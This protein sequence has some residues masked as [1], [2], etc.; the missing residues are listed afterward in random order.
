MIKQEN[1]LELSIMYVNIYIICKDPNNEYFSYFLK[2]VFS[3]SSDLVH[4]VLFGGLN[5][6]F[7]YPVY[8]RLPKTAVLLLSIYPLL[9]QALL[10]LYSTHVTDPS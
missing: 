8:V 3:R 7:S 2:I 10:H 1:R 9:H 6:F 5:N 4:K